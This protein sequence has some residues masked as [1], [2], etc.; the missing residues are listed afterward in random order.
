MIKALFFLGNPGK[1]YAKTRH[2]AAW[3][4]CDLLTADFHISEPWNSKF[5]ALY[6]ES[7]S[8]IPQKLILCRPQVFMNNSGSS[9]QGLTRFFRL[10]GKE[11][12]VVHDDLET[13]F[14]KLTMQFAGGHGGHNGVRSIIQS[15]GTAD[16]FRLK[17][18]I[19]RPQK[20]S[21]SSFVLSRFTP[22]EEISLEKVL[23]AAS[24]LLLSEL[25]LPE[26]HTEKQSRSITL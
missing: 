9:V 2:N 1:Q 14:G 23:H 16:F 21:V 15:L 17:I 24:S 6:C 4:F 18:G 13:P 7:F 8:L 22:D 25:A 5:H 11:I 26:P 3:Q 10:S 12:L 19:G 20:G